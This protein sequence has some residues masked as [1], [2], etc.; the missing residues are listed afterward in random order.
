LVSPP[1][2]VGSPRFDVLARLGDGATGRVLRAYDKQLAREV[3]IKVPHERGARALRQ[4]REQFEA[5]R[6]LAHPGLMTLYELFEQADPPFFTMELVEGSTL[7]DYVRSADGV[8]DEQKLRGALIQLARALRVL[9]RAGRLHGDLKPGHVRVTSEGRVV[10]LDLGV[11]PHIGLERAWLG[12]AQYMAPEQA[13]S[14]PT[15][16]SD[17]YALGSVLFEC[18]TGELPFRGGSE[19][20][21]LRKHTSEAP[22]ATSLPALESLS[23]L[24]SALLSSEPSRRPTVSQ[25]LAQLE[26]RLSEQPA[27][28][29]M[30]FMLGALPMIGREREL[31]RAIAV[32]ALGA[33]EGAD[34]FVLAESGAGKSTFLHHCV[35]RLRAADRSAWVL[36]DRC[37]PRPW[38]PYQGVSDALN[39]LIE[40]LKERQAE[41]ALDL[42]PTDAHLFFDV[43]PGFRRL[44]AFARLE[45]GPRVPDPVERRWRAFAA[46]RS[47]LANL[48][49]RVPVTIVIDDVHWADGDTLT[50]LRTLMDRDHFGIARPPVRWLLASNAPLP[51]ELDA[52]DQIALMPLTHEQALDLASE[53]TSRARAS[54]L[55]G[56]ASHAPHRQPRQIVELV[57]HALLMGDGQAEDRATLSSLFERRVAQLDH[58]TAHVLLTCVVAGRPIAVTQLALATELDAVQLTRSLGILRSTGLIVDRTVHDERSVEPAC[59]EVRAAVITAFDAERLKD[60][61]LRLVVA[62]QGTE[63]RPSASLLRFQLGSGHLAAARRTAHAAARNAEDVLA[64]E[65]ASHVYELASAAWDG[66]PD[67]VQREVLRALGMMLSCAGNSTRAAESFDRA[68]EGAKVAD[69]LELRRRAAEQWLRGGHLE[70]GMAQL[71]ELLTSVG[72]QLPRSGHQA[73]RSMLFQRLRLSLRGLSFTRKTS[74]QLSAR[75]LTAIDVYWSVGTSIG[76]VDFVSGADFQTRAVSAALRAGEPSRIG[77][78]LALEAI[79]TSVSEKPPCRRALQMIDSAVLIADELNDAHVR[80]IALLARSTVQLAQAAFRQG[81]ADAAS[82]EQLF[83]ERC[84]GVVWEVGQAQHLRLLNLLQL[85]D[86]REIVPRSAR[87]MREAL[88]RGDLYGHTS[89]VT[90]SG[91]FAPLLADDPDAADSLIDEA[92]AHWPKNAFHMQHFFELVARTQVDLYRGG[93]LALRRMQAAWPGLSKSML[94]RVPMVRTSAQW[95][96]A[97]SQLAALDHQGASARDAARHV[98]RAAKFLSKKPASYSEPFIQLMLSQA[99][100]VEGDKH[101]ALTH[102]LRARAD[103]ERFELGLI[104]HSTR[105]WCAVA[106]G[107]S[108]TKNVQAQAIA[109]LSE[110]GF[111]NPMRYMRQNLPFLRDP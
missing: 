61:H 12:S 50:L 72:A 34:L 48:A 94:M 3:A 29:S 111:R 53:L 55:L 57:R 14:E 18:L 15:A 107:D 40:R 13:S 69:A 65:H 82:A 95:L 43:F 16:A 98:R 47:F 17:L 49:Q 51:R 32:C 52:L 78:A 97:L 96:W 74:R 24:C 93:P 21:L 75:E 100:W 89:I 91:Y 6:A 77:K 20:I 46:L 7:R 106:A 109:E 99:S 5:L 73:L 31:E 102:A 76:L 85:G 35:E 30:S 38:Q 8:C 33:D 9:H 104:R 86:F 64:F 66:E 70:Q 88:D 101:A 67:D 68:S 84:T 62:G 58:P 56:D 37:E 105:Y 81:A 44:S 60:A 41:W 1:D 79:F 22:R 36:V 80:G 54:E 92:M 45:E 4:L 110:L 27:A 63:Q 19:R 2:G 25:V 28:H 59:L 83:R 87:Y 42:V 10:L 23:Q 108:D 90:L 26:P 71:S 103:V 11:A 39:Q